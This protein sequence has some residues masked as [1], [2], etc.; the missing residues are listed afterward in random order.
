MALLG[1]NIVDS[2]DGLAVQS[3]RCPP[4]HR[5]FREISGSLYPK[6]TSPRVLLVIKAYVDD[7]GGDDKPAVAMA[8]LIGV[9]ADW[10][11]LEQGWESILSEYGL[12]E[13][14]GKKMIST[15]DGRFRG[16]CDGWEQA[17]INQMMPAFA[18]VIPDT[19]IMIGAGT[20]VGDYATAA[21]EFPKIYENTSVFAF[22]MH[23][24]LQTAALTAKEFFP[25]EPMA[26]FL[27]RPKRRRGNMGA[28]ADRYI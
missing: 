26:L 11:V 16:Y 15:K 20:F 27:D 19:L 24:L 1:N 5:Y 17:K 23:H 14:H 25:S 2:R 12:P 18:E 10:T 6:R 7:T 21:R 9:E 13:Y 28:I 8:G 4:A 22:L 3:P